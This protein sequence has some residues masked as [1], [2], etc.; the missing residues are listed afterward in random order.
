MLAPP[1]CAPVYARMRGIRR[2]IESPFGARRVRRCA[3]AGAL[4]RGAARRAATRARSCCRTRGSRRSIPWLARIPRAHRLRRRSALGA[5]DRRAPARPQGAC[6]GSSTRYAALAAAPGTPACRCRRRRCSCPTSPT[7]PR[8]MRALRLDDANA[9]WRSC[10]PAPSTAR[11]S[12]GRRSSSPSSRARF[13]RDGI[14]GLAR[15][16]AQRQARAPT[17]CSKALGDQR[18]AGA[19]PH[20]H[21]PTSAR[22]S[23]CCR[24]ASIV[25]SNDSG[26][27]HAAAAVGVPLVALF[28]SSS[29]VYTPPLSPL[30]RIARIDIECSPCFKRECP[31]G[32]FKC[33]RD[34]AAAS[35]STISRARRPH[36]IPR[37]HPPIPLTTPPCPRP[38]RLPI[39]TSPQDVALA[40]YQAFETQRHRRDDGD[41]GRRRGHRLR[42]P[43]R[44]AASS[45]TTPV[46]TAWEQL[47][48][49]DTQAR[50]PA[51]PGRRAGDGRPRDAERD[52]AHLH[53]RD[54]TRARRGRRH[55]R[56][57]AHAVGLA[58]RLPSRLAGAARVS[59]APAVRVRCTRRLR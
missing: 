9:R 14:A 3:S 10:A 27:M 28:G 26:L 43:G 19:R 52:R 41:V 42:A 13:L 8:R 29:P 55:Q 54:G 48:A 17:P 39:Y 44:H 49:G 30:A 34:L 51:R 4:A 37:R 35:W 12:A 25:V 57:H 56:V 32:H 53:R 2:V 16:L 11:P 33:M 40:F 20:R 50:V 1:W 5:A 24:S 15:R 36:P 18:A 47:F 6:R 22:R 31:L 58:D 23:T 21:A 38:A 45:A 59:D 46:R 7:A